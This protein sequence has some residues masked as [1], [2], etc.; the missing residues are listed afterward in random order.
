MRTHR[1]RPR[2]TRIWTLAAALLCVTGVAAQP[3]PV[4]IWY[5]TSE[6][7]P[8]GEFFVARLNGLGQSA[9]LAGVGDRVDFVVTLGHERDTSVGRLERQTRAGTVAIREY[10]D[11]DCAQVAEALALTLDLALAPNAATSAQASVP[12]LAG[13]GP[14][15]AGLPPE[16]SPS[17]DVAV[18]RE[19]PAQLPILESE[20]SL[21]K[22]ALG[23]QAMLATGVAPNALPGAALFLQ[24]ESSAW[25][26]RSLR[27]T[28]LGGHS[29]ST[30]QARELEVTLLGVRGEA[31]PV[32]WSVATRFVV[33]P[34]AGAELGLIRGA[35]AEPP[36]AA[37]ARV[38]SSV[39]GHARAAFRI[40][41]PVWLEAQ[42]GGRVPLV[43]YEMGTRDGSEDWFRTRAVGLDAGVGASW[44]I[45]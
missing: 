32:S 2:C 26:P 27:L 29:D 34:C 31:C 10:Q 24:L 19:G 33:E 11:A 16:R 13:D 38:L 15:P 21:T 43:R 20:A 44:Q 7:C 36:G 25:F 41:G 6:G 9:Q 12:E 4:W 30:T 3:V 18:T 28:L 45:W 22:G 23:A 17:S 39:H 40:G 8:D 1:G 35:S 42:V 14:A 37:H 5:R